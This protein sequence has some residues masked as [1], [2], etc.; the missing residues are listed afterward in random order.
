VKNLLDIFLHLDQH[1]G[2]LSASLGG[3]M[4]AVLAL[5]I[6]VASFTVTATLIMVVLEKRREIAVLKAMGASD[7]AILRIFVYQG[8]IIG[9]LGTGSG[10]LL[11][12]AVCKGL[13][14][15]GF[16]LDPKVYFI[17]KL[18]V[19]VRA[20]EFGLTALVALGICLIATV[21]PALYAVRLRPADGVRPE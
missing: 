13:L 18:P 11:G 4:Y 14:V 8:G 20:F 1:L 21:V 7:S 3:W 10:L 2:A 19:E 16:P 12:L 15:Y 9:M 5:I 17:S 6:F